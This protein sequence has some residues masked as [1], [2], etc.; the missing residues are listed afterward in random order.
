LGVCLGCVCKVRLEGE[1]QDQIDDPLFEYQ[2]VCTEGPVF[3][4]QQIIWD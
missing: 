1:D 4:G 2:R 3:V